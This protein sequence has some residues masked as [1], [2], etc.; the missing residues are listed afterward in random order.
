MFG[1]GIG[2]FTKG[3]KTLGGGIGDVANVSVKGGIGAIKEFGSIAGKGVSF[4]GKGIIEL[5]DN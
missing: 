5:T 4:A 1:S 2:A 3:M